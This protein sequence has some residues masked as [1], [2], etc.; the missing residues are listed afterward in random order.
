MRAPDLARRTG[1]AGRQGDAREIE[2][3]KRRFRR[4]PGNGEGAGIGQARGFRAEDRGRWRQAQQVG[5]QFFAQRRG[6]GRL[7][8]TMPGGLLG[9]RAETGDGGDILGAGAKP[10][11]LPAA[12]NQ[13]ALA[14]QRRLAQHERAGAQRAAQLVRRDNQHVGVRRLECAGNAPRRLHGVADE[15]TAGGMN[16]FGDG[17][18]GLQHAGLV[19]GGLQAEQNRALRASKRGVERGEVEDAAGVH[20]QDF[21]ALAKPVAFERCDVL[22]RRKQ[23]SRRRAL[24]AAPSARQRESQRLGGAGRE[25][26][27]ARAAANQRRDF[28]PCRFHQ[29]AR[30]PAFGMDR[31]RIARRA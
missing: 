3:H 4:Q 9:R 8:V 15:E 25:D 17:G 20:R 29:R 27:I 10:A 23:Q 6:K 24:R 11:L 31:R 14:G 16:L 19:V 28:F 2:S 30:R 12:A 1:G 5:L 7:V 21:G 26:D 13:G 18:D 22:G